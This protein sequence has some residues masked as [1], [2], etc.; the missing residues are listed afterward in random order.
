[1]AMLILGLVV[2]IPLILLAL[3]LACIGIY[4]VIDATL[5]YVSDTVFFMKLKHRGFRID[6]KFVAQGRPVFFVDHEARQWLLRGDG[7]AAPEIFGFSD[8]ME[9]EVH[10]DG[11]M[12][13]RGKSGK[14]TPDHDFLSD[15][16]DD[17]GRLEL[18]IKIN[19]GGSQ[20]RILV[21][22]KF[23]NRF[24]DRKLAVMA[25][26]RSLRNLKEAVLKM[27]SIQKTVAGS[28]FAS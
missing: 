18:K 12:V 11:K 21:F 4:W 15:A 3:A 5:R 14:L 17:C 19:D 23:R 24:R 27:L 6:E 20:Q 22:M 13:A 28:F 2:L 1:M 10:K 8:L 16:S 26:R 9:F 25:Y 7:L